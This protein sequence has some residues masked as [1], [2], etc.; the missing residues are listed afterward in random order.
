MEEWL[1]GGGCEPA[2]ATAPS[3]SLT[4][5]AALSPGRAWWLTSLDFLLGSPAFR[6][7]VVRDR[8]TAPT[9][10]HPFLVAGLLA[11]E[12]WLSA[13]CLVV[14]PGQ[15]SAEELSRELSLYLPQRRVLY[16]PARE[17]WYGPEAELPP[18]VAGR[19]AEALA[20]L[21]RPGVVV[22]EA[23]TLMEAA[24][25]AARPP[26]TL[27]VGGQQDFDGLTRELV[28][29]GLQPAGPGRG[30]R[31]LRRARR[32]R[33]HFPLHGPSSC[34][35]GI[36]GRRDRESA[37]LLGLF[38]TVAGRRAVRGP[39]PGGGGGGWR[40]CAHPGDLGAGDHARVSGP[41][42]VLCPP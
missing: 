35:G 32:A 33:R 1:S 26:L 18:R 17:V 39:D 38:A 37:Q 42:G 6:E 40:T 7:A 41:R 11:Q 10:A 3:R 28:D 12:P 21:G 30:S 2:P 5:A 22:V 34:P 15:D 27:A 31:G 8:L 20:A 13:P 25:P 19:R 36:L 24:V 9:F 29:L 14:A 16:L 23:T 4:R